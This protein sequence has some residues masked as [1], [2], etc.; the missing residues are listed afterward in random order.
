M[1][2]IIDALRR[3]I[4]RP[5][6]VPI[7]SPLRWEGNRCAMGLHPLARHKQPIIVEDLPIPGVTVA[8][9]N[10]FVGWFDNE[11]SGSKVVEAIWG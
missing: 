3:D 10:E 11:T 4:P 6:T 5:A 8:E 9:I 1:K 2:T 7:G